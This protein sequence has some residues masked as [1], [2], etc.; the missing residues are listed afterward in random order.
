MFTY[1]IQP[2]FGCPEDRTLGKV[3]FM[4]GQAAGTTTGITIDPR[5]GVAPVNPLADLCGL[6]LPPLFMSAGAAWMIVLYS[7]RR[8]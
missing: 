8:F 1:R 4:G 6:G 2:P 5:T 7:R 3:T